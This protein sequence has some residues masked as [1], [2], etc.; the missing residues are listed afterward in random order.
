M[1]SVIYVIISALL[2][3][4]LSF[5]VI[6]SRTKHRISVGDGDNEELQIAQGAQS[7]AIEM[8]RSH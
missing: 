7:N 6:K 1:I 3:I 4:Y 2:I 8:C 5:A